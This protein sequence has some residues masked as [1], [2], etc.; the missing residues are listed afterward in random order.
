MSPDKPDSVIA[1]HD[2]R[3]VAFAQLVSSESEVDIAGGGGLVRVEGSDGANADS[4]EVGKQCLVPIGH[5]VENTIRANRFRSIKQLPG[6]VT[7]Q[8]LCLCQ[9]ENDKRG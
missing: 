5:V 2:S 1:T 6:L 7:L 9:E 8:L 4:G 3:H